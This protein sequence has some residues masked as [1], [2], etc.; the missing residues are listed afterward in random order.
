M[1]H[2]SVHLDH[3]RTVKLTIENPTALTWLPNLYP[4][5]KPIHASI[6]VYDITRRHSFEEAKKLVTEFSLEARPGAFVALVGNKRDRKSRREVSFKV[7]NVA[8]FI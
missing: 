4:T 3:D 8:M 7:S 1:Y 6:V 2:K 5:F